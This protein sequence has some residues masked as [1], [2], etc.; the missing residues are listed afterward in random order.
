MRPPPLASDT[1]WGPLLAVPLAFI[2]AI[3]G[4]LWFDLTPSQI[5]LVPSVLW[6]V[7]MFM[8]ATI[9]TTI[10]TML[11]DSVMHWPATEYV[12]VGDTV[13]GSCLYQAGALV[14]MGMFLACIGW[15]VLQVVAVNLLPVG[16][17]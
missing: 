16:F 12:R 3:Y 11:A 4:L 8:A 2:G 5:G 7:G 6:F 13:G 9:P 10:I 15:W 17:R 1:T 14:C